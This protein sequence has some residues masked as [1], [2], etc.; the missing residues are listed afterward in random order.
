MKAKPYYNATTLSQLLGVHYKT[1][2]YW[3]K[4]DKLKG[5]TRSPI[6][7]EIRIPKELAHKLAKEH[8]KTIKV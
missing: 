2:L 5:A 6:T 7:K 8:G 3:W 4:N 1:V